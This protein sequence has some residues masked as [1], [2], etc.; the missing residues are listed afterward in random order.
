MGVLN[1]SVEGVNASGSRVNGDFLHQKWAGK[2]A[3]GSET[4]GAWSEG[5]VEEIFGTAD[6]AD[7][8]RFAVRRIRERRWEAR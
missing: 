3:N 6:G 4:K 2:D 7:C 1:G 8:R 5:K